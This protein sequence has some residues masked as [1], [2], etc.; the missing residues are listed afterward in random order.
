[1]IQFNINIKKMDKIIFLDITL[2]HAR[3]AIEILNNTDY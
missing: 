1:M 3:K 2:E